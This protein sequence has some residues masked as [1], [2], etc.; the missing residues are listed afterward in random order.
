MNLNHFGAAFDGVLVLCLARTNQAG[1]EAMWEHTQQQR[2]W[3]FRPL[4]FVKLCVGRR[5]PLAEAQKIHSAPF[6]EEVGTSAP[7]TV[8]LNEAGFDWKYS[9]NA[10][11]TSALVWREVRTPRCFFFCQEVYRF[12]RVWRR[13]FDVARDLFHTPYHKHI[14]EM[15][16]TRAGAHRLELMT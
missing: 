13:R 5:L 6:E 15:I 4:T 12:I 14:S 2:H 9:K 11:Q 8:A 7:N 10:S 16:E 3:R 1:N